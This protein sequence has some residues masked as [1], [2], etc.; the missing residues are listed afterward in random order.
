MCLLQPQSLHLHV[1]ERRRLYDMGS[2]IHTP[3]NVKDN[4]DRSRARPTSVVMSV[5]TSALLEKSFVAPESLFD[6]PFELEGMSF[7]TKVFAYKRVLSW[8][9]RRLRRSLLAKDHI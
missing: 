2:N 6:G 7:L 9:L 8:R 4:L 5:M 1:H 3:V